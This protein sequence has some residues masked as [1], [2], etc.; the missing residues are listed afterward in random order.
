M[1]NLFF[2]TTFARAPFRYRKTTP[3]QISH[4]ADHLKDAYHLDKEHTLRVNTLF[5]ST[6]GN[7]FAY[8]ACFS[9]YIRP[10]RT[11][12][13]R[14]LSPAENIERL[15]VREVYKLRAVHISQNIKA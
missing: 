9:R 8:T 4:V 15:T 1:N 12:N 10:C 5:H 7:S 3:S 6:K 11:R 13:Q 2:H 14:S